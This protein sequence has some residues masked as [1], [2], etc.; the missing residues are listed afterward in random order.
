MTNLNQNTE[1]N[2]TT[3]EYSRIEKMIKQWITDR[4]CYSNISDDDSLFF[5]LTGINYDKIGIT[6]QTGNDLIYYDTNIYTNDDNALKRIKNEYYLKNSYKEIVE[7]E[8]FK[9]ITAKNIELLKNAEYNYNQTTGARVGDFLLLPHGEYTRF[10]HKW[11]ET[12]QTG[13]GSNSYHLSN[14]GYISYSG[15]LDSGV[16]YTDIEQ[17]NNTKAGFI[18][19]WDNGTSGADRGVHFKINFRVFTLKQGADLSGLPQIAAHAKREFLKGCETITRINGNNQP[20][21]LPVPEII[22]KAEN[23]NEVFLTTLRENT[24]LEFI[25]SFFGYSVQPTKLEQ[26]AKLLLTHNFK[27]TFYNNST[28]N[29]TLMLEFNRN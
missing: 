12:I 19:I 11:N 3:L 24:G 29:N 16:K 9:K 7:N 17:S 21:T 5:Q 18:W 2:N 8:S 20:Y 10:T 28:Y 15:G 23:L 1:T 13:G 22:I 27:S 4:V 26:I 14:G 25:K 6:S